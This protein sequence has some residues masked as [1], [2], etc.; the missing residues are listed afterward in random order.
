MKASKI[1]HPLELGGTL[2]VPAAHKNLLSVASGAKFPQLKSMV[3][4]FEDGLDTEKIDFG[5][6]QLQSLLKSEKPHKLLRFIRP[7]N[8]EMLSNL[9][10]LANIEKIN[11]FVLPKFG[12]KNAQN[13]LKIIQDSTAKVQHLIMPSI[14]GE[15]LFN[16]AQLQ[17][18]KTILLPFQKNIILIR[19]GAEDMLRQLS[20]RRDCDTSLFDINVTA[21]VIS[22][23][24]TTF[25]PAGF[26][27]SAPV[28][29]CFE[30]DE[31]FLN[32]VQRDLKEGLISKTIIHPRQIALLNESYKV[33]K[34]VLE[35]AKAILSSKHAV[36]NLNNTMAESKTMSP[37]AE[38]IQMRAKYY[39]TY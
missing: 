21:L 20:M 10:T 27:I 33:S 17:E 30:R 5:F 37:W 36:F 28:F 35:E 29:R 39:G 34:S 12:L 24:I 4:D 11:G 38:Q 6:E 3:I 31:D 2:F 7:R 22:N 25:K 9:I 26:A 8:P 32:D 16:T 18:L 1:I 19:F 13:Y 23:L 15:E 14:E